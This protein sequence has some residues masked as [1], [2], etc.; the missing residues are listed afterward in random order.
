LTIAFIGLLALKKVLHFAKSRKKWGTYEICG[1]YLDIEFNGKVFTPDEG[2]PYAMDLGPDFYAA[3]N[4]NIA[5]LEDDRVI[6]M[7]WLDSWN[8]GLNTTHWSDQVLKANQNFLSG[9]NSKAFNFE[10]E[11]DLEKTTA[12]QVIFQITD[13]KIVYDIT[14]KLL[15][16][17]LFIPLDNK[18]Q[19]RML[20]DW[21]HVKSKDFI[22]WEYLPCA[23]APDKT[24]DQHGC[25]SGSAIEWDGKHLI[26]YTGVEDII[27]EEGESYH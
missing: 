23:L 15:A 21:G 17:K 8:G 22:T 1:K 2:G 4:F 24:Y 6:E 14:E 12:T 9:I 25:F 7:A 19:I 3:Q 11:I 20:V 10:V 26:A 18:V 13:Q 16:G 5:S 27:D